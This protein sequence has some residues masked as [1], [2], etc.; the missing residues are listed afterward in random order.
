M[1][2]L[3]FPEPLSDGHVTLRPFRAGDIPALVRAC[4][5]REIVRWTPVPVGY[6]ESMAKGWIASHQAALLEGRSIPLAVM[7]AEGDRLLGAIELHL[8]FPGAS[9]RVGY[10]VAEWARGHGVATRA[11]RLVRDFAFDT[12]GLTRLELLAHPHNF[13]SQR[14]A[15]RAGFTP[16]GASPDRLRFGLSRDPRGCD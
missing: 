12:L 4:A 3:S 8:E 10:W 16:Q 1:A 2:K 9:G 13:P 14:V 6:D 7:D 11:V 15:A 5:D